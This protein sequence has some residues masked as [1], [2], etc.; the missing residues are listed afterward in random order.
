MARPI[1]LLP[2]VTN[3]VEAPGLAVMVCS[4]VIGADQVNVMVNLAR[5]VRHCR[6][7]HHCR[8]SG[9][10]LR[11]TTARA[12]AGVWTM[13]DAVLPREARTLILRV[14]AD[15]LLAPL[16]VDRLS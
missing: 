4:L 2:P 15:Q 3:A 10:S 13:V 12:P 7:A 16:M 11:L 1:R 8:N 5:W 9:Y 6:S 14:R